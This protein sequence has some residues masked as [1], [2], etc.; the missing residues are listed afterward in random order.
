MPLIVDGY[1]VLFCLA[2]HGTNS[3]PEAIEGARERL[4]RLLM[5][6]L[7]ATGQS[8]TVV[9]DRKVPSGGARREETLGGVR[10]LY[11]HPPHTADDDIRR[12]VETSTAPHTLRVVTS[13]RELGNACSRCGA[14]VVSASAFL[15]DLNGVVAAARA[16]ETEQR[17]KQEPPSEDELRYWLNVFGGDE[18]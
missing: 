11:T 8:I 13:D 3:S 15:G 9:F 2:P 14:A 16:N 18:Q 17:M 6:Y 4:L 12:M 1:N 7:Q 10:I 5:S